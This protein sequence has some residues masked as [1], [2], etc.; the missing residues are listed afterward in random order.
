MRLYLISQNVVDGCGTYE[1]AVVAAD[2]ED[3]ARTIHP[4]FRVTHV[5]DWNWVGWG[6]EFGEYE[7]K[8]SSWVAYSDI[9]QIKVEY[10]G[11]TVKSRGLILS[12]RRRGRYAA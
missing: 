11:E 7:Y 4:S 9:Q 8:E 5:N 12:S 2:S 3:E 1:A 6:T 10:L